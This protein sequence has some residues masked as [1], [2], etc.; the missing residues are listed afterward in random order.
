VIEVDGFAI[1]T[2]QFVQFRT[3]NDDEKKN[4]PKSISISA[5][6]AFDAKLIMHQIAG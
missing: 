6:K 5:P 1:E 2:R 3:L 4:I